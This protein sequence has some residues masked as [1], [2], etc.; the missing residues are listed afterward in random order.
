MSAPHRNRNPS[1]TYRQRRLR[2]LQIAVVV[3]AVVLIGF[4]Y[5][6]LFIGI[7]PTSPAGLFMTL[8][9]GLFLWLF[10]RDTLR[11]VEGLRMRELAERWERNAN[12][13]IR[14]PAT[15]SDV[16]VDE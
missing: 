4:T 14:V 15:S 2:R 1:S 8:G 9:V 3:S 11:Y 13:P 12:Q 7:H 5:I 6:L 16:P 10:W